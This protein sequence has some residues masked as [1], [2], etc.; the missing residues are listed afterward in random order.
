M[1]VWGAAL[2]GLPMQ[3]NVI[4]TMMFILAILIVLSAELIGR[5][6]AKGRA[7]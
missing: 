3:V 1:F 2:R 7:T 5:Q 4:G 6:R